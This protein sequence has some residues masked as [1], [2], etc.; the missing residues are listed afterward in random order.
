MRNIDLWLLVADFGISSNL[1][2]V[3]E[4]IEISFETPEETHE[5][6]LLLIFYSGGIFENPSKSLKTRKRNIRDIKE[7]FIS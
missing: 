7:S 2:T 3:W 4:I 6:L 5:K 1:N